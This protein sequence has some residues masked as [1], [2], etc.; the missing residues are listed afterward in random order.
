MLS[1]CCK[2]ITWSLWEMC[3]VVMKFFSFPPQIAAGSREKPLAL[4]VTSAVLWMTAALRLWTGS[5]FIFWFVISQSPIPPRLLLGK[6]PAS[7]PVLVTK[8]LPSSRN[9]ARCVCV[10]STEIRGLLY[11][12]ESRHSTIFRRLQCIPLKF[13][14]FRHRR[15]S[16]TENVGSVRLE[17]LLCH[18]GFAP[19]DMTSKEMQKRKM[20]VKNGEICFTWGGKLGLRNL[21]AVVN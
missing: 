16:C 18:W 9:C 20:K 7:Y 13:I 19:N 8:S 14:L 6:M 5:F 21:K 2:A 10:S 11:L 3:P 1:T 12:Q 4:S 15:G 17:S